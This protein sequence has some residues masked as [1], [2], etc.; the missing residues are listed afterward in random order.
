[1]KP[2]FFRAAVLAACAFSLCMTSSLAQGKFKQLEIYVNENKTACWQMIA[3]QNK[4]GLLI[5]NKTGQQLTLKFT[6]M[7]DLPVNADSLA[8]LTQTPISTITWL[9]GNQS[10]S[11]LMPPRY[12]LN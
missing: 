7:P 2:V 4:P 1:M 5:H 9:V 3:G 11:A 10:I 8:S 6:D 12:L